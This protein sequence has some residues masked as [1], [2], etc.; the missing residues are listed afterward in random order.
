[1]QCIAVQFDAEHAQYVHCSAQLGA[2]YQCTGH[3]T[4]SYSALM[5]LCTVDYAH[6]Q[7]CNELHYTLQFSK[8]HCI[9]CTVDPAMMYCNI[10]VLC[11]VQR[12]QEWAGSA[13]LM[14]LAQYSNTAPAPYSLHCTSL[15]CTAPHCTVLYCTVHHFSA[16][17]C[18]ALNSTSLNVAAI[19]EGR[20]RRKV[21]QIHR[22][23]E[24]CLVHCTPLTE[25]SNSF[26]FGARQYNN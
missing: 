14:Q 3:C 4:A 5:T 15:H 25:Q 16:I 6:L 2:I 26:G 20:T 7:H 23:A 18:S 1:M 19:P 12:T 13:S 9:F 11:T 10:A 21:K 8:M 22:K 24:W 17:H